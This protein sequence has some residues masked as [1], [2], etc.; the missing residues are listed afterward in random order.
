MIAVRTIVATAALA[1]LAGCTT[2]ENARDAI[3]RPASACVDQT[4]QVYFEPDSAEV[5]DEGR[6]VIRQAAEQA[7][8][9]TV[10]RIDVVGLADATGAP[11]A[12]LELSGRRASAVTAALSA[13]GLPTAQVHMAAAGQAGAVTADG[14]AAPLRRRADVILRLSR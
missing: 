2:L 7:R 6:A 13:S 5:T 14:A 8:G 9:C 3:V 10:R 11:D 12:N 4:V 1:A